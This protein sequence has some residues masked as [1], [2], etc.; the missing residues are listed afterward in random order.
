M[1]ETD[2]ARSAHEA[3]PHTPPGG[4][5]PETPAPFPWSIDGMQGERICQGFATP[6]QNAALDRFAPLAKRVNWDEGKGAS[7]KTTPLGLPLVGT[8]ATDAFGA[9]RRAMRAM[10]R[11]LI[12]R[13][14]EKAPLRP[15]DPAFRR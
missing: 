15:P 9:A 12:L 10:R 7:G 6:A 3:L 5:P 1:V 4:T 13:Q 2:G 11:C 14:G 8:A